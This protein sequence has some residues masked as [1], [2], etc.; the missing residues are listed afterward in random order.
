MSIKGD[1]V[2]GEGVGCGP[3]KRNLGD[4]RRIS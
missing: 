1:V 4:N 3:P 2:E